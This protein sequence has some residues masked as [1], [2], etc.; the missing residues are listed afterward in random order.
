MHVK[1]VGGSH[2]KLEDG[3]ADL[4]CCGR[5]SYRN[6]TT[7]PLYIRKRHTAKHINTKPRQID[8]EDAYGEHAIFY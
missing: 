7:A 2:V 1:V 5:I 6:K 4:Q 3:R 8:A